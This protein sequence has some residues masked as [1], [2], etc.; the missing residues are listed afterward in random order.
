MWI[1]DFSSLVLIIGAGLQLG[2][3]GLFGW[4]AAAAIFGAYT[5]AAY[6][7]GGASA[8]WQLFRQLPLR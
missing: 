8:I 6:I 7:F 4:D 2:I 1:I 5:K 3:L